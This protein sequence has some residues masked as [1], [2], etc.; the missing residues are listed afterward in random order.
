MRRDSRESSL[1]GY[2]GLMSRRRRNLKRYWVVILLAI[3]AAIVGL[4][5]WPDNDS[6]NLNTAVEQ[7]SSA[8]QPGVEQPSFPVI[9]LQATIDTWV[10]KQS[11]RAGI[12]VYDLANKK[13]VA[14]INPDRQYFTASLYKLYVAYIGYQKI[15]DGTY[16]A[17]D[18]Y[19]SGYSRGKCLDAMIRDSYSPC[20]EKMWSELG[21]QQLTEK[22]KTYGLSNTSMTGLYTSAEDAALI[23]ARLFERRDLTEAYTNA[24]L[25]SLK[26]QDVKFRTG[27]PSGFAKSAVYNK[28]GWNGT[29]EWHDTAIVTLPNRRS[30]VITVLSENIGSAQVA[31]LGQAIEARL[32]Q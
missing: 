14:S 29:V 8:N 23:L 32:T 10:A 2:T 13:I 12:V 16:E 5:F 11:G 3:V 1:L 26:D 15:A 20:G 22:L 21:K 25:S 31:S 27:L 18:P 9:N 6:K 28:V 24:Y 30:Y 4:I 7:S 17:N 19:L